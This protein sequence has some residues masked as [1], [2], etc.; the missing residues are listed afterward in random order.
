MKKIYVVLFFIVLSLGLSGCS[1]KNSIDDKTIIVGASVSP[2]AEILE[3]TREYI[4]SKGYKLKIVEY[5]DY[6]Q[7][8]VGVNDGSL[9]ANFFQHLPYLNQYNIDNKTSLVSA[10]EVHFEPLAIYQGKSKTIQVSDGASIG[11]PNDTTNEARALLL[12]DS[13]GLIEIDKTK[14]LKVTKLDIINNPKNLKIIELE[15]AIIP[16]K[17]PDLD[18]AVIN[19]NVALTAGIIDKQIPFTQEKKDSEAAKTYANVICVKE[20]NEDKEAIKI[21]IEALKSQKI[22]DFI[23]ENYQGLVI[24]L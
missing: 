8:N 18:L 5:T 3:Q 21:L 17:L 7:P 10:Y 12:L 19:G 6:V 16:T 24:P 15:A 1:A 22:I 4:E 11:V 23:N 2:H 9:D 20:G 13:L 14:G